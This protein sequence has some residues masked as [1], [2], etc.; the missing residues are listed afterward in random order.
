MEGLI[1]KDSALKC[2]E[3]ILNSTN[4]LVELEWKVMNLLRRLETCAVDDAPQWISVKDKLPDTTVKV[5]VYAGNKIAT[6][7][8]TDFS[9]PPGQWDSYDCIRTDSITH[10]MQL[11]E[12]PQED[13]EET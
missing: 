12:P 11:P 10:W 13:N 6:A 5:V 3:T 1:S 2:I 4:G 7:W 9:N 8:R